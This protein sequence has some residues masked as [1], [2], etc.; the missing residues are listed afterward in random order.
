MKLISLF[1]QT[2][3]HTNP[4][5]ANSRRKHV[6]DLCFIASPTRKSVSLL[7]MFSTWVHTS[8][9]MKLPKLQVT[10]DQL[11]ADE[12]QAVVEK[13]VE[14][15]NKVAA[16]VQVIK[17]D[18]QKV[19]ACGRRTAHLAIVSMLSGHDLTLKTVQR[20]GIGWYCWR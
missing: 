9:D 5:I 16:N 10:A 14:E 11:A 12:Q 3:I 19:Q 4:I 15:A 20:L 7:G 17:D 1:A 13:D 2:R 8:T 6:D 18:C